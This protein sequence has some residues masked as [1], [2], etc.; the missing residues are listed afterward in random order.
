ML[1][2]ID[3]INISKYRK[4]TREAPTKPCLW[5]C[6]IKIDNLEDVFEVEEKI[7]I[8]EKIFL[9]IRLVYRSGCGTI[10]LVVRL[11]CLGIS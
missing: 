6:M 8:V 2:I 11:E 9:Q 4:G 10:T 5:F 7:V 1:D 3:I